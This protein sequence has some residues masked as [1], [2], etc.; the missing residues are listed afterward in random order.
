VSASAEPVRWCYYCKKAHLLSAFGLGQSPPTPGWAV[1]GDNIKT[2]I[3]SAY[4]FISALEVK[5]KYNEPLSKF[6]FEFN[7]RR[8]V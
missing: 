6:A 5:L 7:L 3:Q 8:F 1:Q 2:P 4:A